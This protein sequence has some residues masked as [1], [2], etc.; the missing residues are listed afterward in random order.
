[1]VRFLLLMTISVGVFLYTLSFARLQV[2]RGKLAGAVSAVV[3]AVGSLGFS[4]ATL[5]KL[6]T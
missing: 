3:L 4:T 1:M 2:A 5:W 6:L